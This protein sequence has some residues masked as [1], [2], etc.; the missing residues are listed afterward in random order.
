MGEVLKSKLAVIVCHE[1]KAPGAFG[2]APL[3]MHEY[4]YGTLLAEKMKAYADSYMAHLIEV[5]VFFR[6][7]IGIK[8]AYNQALSWIEK[9]PLDGCAIIEPHFNAVPEHLKGKVHGTE[10]LMCD[11]RDLAWVNEN[12]YAALIH[13]VILDTLDTK[14][15]GIKSRP[16]SEGEAGWYNV[17]QTV[18]YPSILPE[19]FFGDH[20]VDAAKGLARMEPLARNIVDASVKFFKARRYGISDI[21]RA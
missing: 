12:L 5:G 11:L 8:G 20:P 2:V 3:D 16:E 18:H 4:Q 19:L 10:T 6:D 9:E 7:G 13:Q 14:D 15:R 21:A 1:R 17:N